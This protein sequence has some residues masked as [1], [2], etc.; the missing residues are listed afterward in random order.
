MHRKRINIQNLNT[1]FLK[2]SI[3]KQVGMS[4]IEVLISLFIMVTGILGAVAMQASA[5]KGSF[6]AMQRSLASTLAQDIVERM[7]NNDSATLASYAANSPYGSG[8]IVASPTCNAAT[9]VC[10]P[11]LMVTHDLFGWE[12]AI[13]GAGATD[14]VN[15]VGG[16]VGGI[17]CLTVNGNEVTVVVTWQSKAKH[18]D[19]N[20]AAG[21]GTASDT[22][23]QVVINAFII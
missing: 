10:A 22:R 1:H 4:F 19:A 20:K 2:K 7:R 21:C 13:M 9:A 15:N 8:K 18:T 17:G 11:A 6:D 16:L 3:S 14:G 5:Q 12:Q 23:R